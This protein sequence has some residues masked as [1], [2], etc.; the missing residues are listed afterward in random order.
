MTKDI[1]ELARSVLQ[2]SR[3]TLVLHLRFM[4]TAISRLKWLS[5]TDAFAAAPELLG[6]RL[7]TEGTVLLYD[8]LEVCRAYAADKASGPRNYLHLLHCVFRHFEVSP[9]VQQDLWNLACD[10][11]V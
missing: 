6:I 2:L 3:N 9:T 1:S 5:L 10:M 7:A 8:P 4:D 11:A